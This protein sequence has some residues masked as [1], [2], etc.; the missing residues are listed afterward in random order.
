MARPCLFVEE[1]VVVEQILL[2]HFKV[3][4]TC[5]KISGLKKEDYEILDVNQD[6]AEIVCGPV[7]QAKCVE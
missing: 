4:S 1:A 3:Y 6:K 2:K 5:C 7:L